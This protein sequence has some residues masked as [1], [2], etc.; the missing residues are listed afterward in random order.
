LQ[1]K[2][3][4][5][6]QTSDQQTILSNSVFIVHGHDEA[7]KETTARF[8]SKLGLDPIILHEQ[9]SEGKTIIEKIENNA[10]QISFAVVLLTPDDQCDSKGNKT[11]KGRPRQ[12]VIY[13]LGF[14][15]AKLT[16]SHVCVL[17]KGNIEMLS[18]YLG[19]VYVEM[20]SAGAWKTQLVR[21]IK[22]AG[23]SVSPENLEKDLLS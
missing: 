14:F 22:A 9:P 18:D 13:E 17:K 15:N 11:L 2:Y 20:D 7:A 6:S 3:L 23:L 5:N 16:R 19:V 8:I 4:S 12:N 21:E 1:N 10:E